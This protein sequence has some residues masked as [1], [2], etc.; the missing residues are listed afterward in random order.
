MKKFIIP[1]GI[2]FIISGLI[3]ICLE[4]LWRGH[5]HWTMFLCAGLCGLVMA[6]I[7]NN[8]LT[9]ETDSR[10]QVLVSALC[11]TIC[12][13]LFGIIFNGDFTIWDYRNTWGTIHCLGDQ[14]NILFFG[15]WI[16]ISIFGLPFLDWM[17]WKLGLENKPYYKIGQ[18]Y[19][20]PWEEKDKWHDK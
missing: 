8:L 7:N 19:I 6:N 2:I 3:Y 20:Y 16:L 1:Y 4:L 18:K 10:K 5:S 13:F 17:Q 9:F 12:E 11:C 14:V 15:I